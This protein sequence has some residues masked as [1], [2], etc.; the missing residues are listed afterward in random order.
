[1]TTNYIFDPVRDVQQ[2][3]QKFEL[4]YSGPPRK[5]PDQL[6]WDRTEQMYEEIDEYSAVKATLHDQL[7]ALVDEVYFVIGTALLHGF[8]F[9][10]AWRRVHEANMKK[11]R[12]KT[13]SD[14]K[15]NDPYDVV[16]P[17]DWRPPD[18][19]DLVSG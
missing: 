19:S 8:D 6:V 15:R 12:A 7:D 14:S 10:E 1:M 9:R 5:L 2:F 16:K 18:L 3:Q 13:A 17:D 11:I 4:T